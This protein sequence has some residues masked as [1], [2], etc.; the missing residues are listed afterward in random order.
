M[1]QS[2]IDDVSPLNDTNYM[3]ITLQYDKIVLPF[4]DGITFLSS[5]NLV[6]S[7]IPTKDYTTHIVKDI[8]LNPAVEI[9]SKQAYLEAKLRG[10]IGEP[11]DA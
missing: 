3:V 7:Y 8:S 5:L 1:T 2:T 11:E 10:L 4:K 9:I 6:E